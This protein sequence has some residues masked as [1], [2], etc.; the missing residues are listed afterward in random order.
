MARHQRDDV[1]RPGEVEWAREDDERAGPLRN[2]RREG[3]V[4]LAFAAR[5]EHEEPL[6]RSAS[7]RLCFGRLRLCRRHVRVYQ[8]SEKVR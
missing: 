2:E 3:R 5:S 1:M 6:P 7:C 4:D 8:Q